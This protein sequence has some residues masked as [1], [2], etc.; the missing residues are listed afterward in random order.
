MLEKLLLDV[1]HFGF[2]FFNF[3]LQLL[4]FC[5]NIKQ[6]VMLPTWAH[7]WV[8]VGLL[9]WQLTQE[10]RRNNIMYNFQIYDLYFRASFYGRFLLLH[11]TKQ[12]R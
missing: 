2:F 6:P 7:I 11:P 10:V 5:L 8:A 3:Y 9:T 4:W 12:P 1:D